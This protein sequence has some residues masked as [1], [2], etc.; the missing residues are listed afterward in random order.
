MENPRKQLIDGPIPGMGMTAELGG[1]PWQKPPQYNTVEEALEFY[2]PR[3]TEPEIIEN[4][5]DVMEL[6]IPLTTIAEGMQ[7]AA[8]ME[9]MHTIDVGI[10]VIPVLVEMMA[11]IGDDAGVEYSTGLEKPINQ[12]NFDDT[13]IALAMKKL[14]E[15]LPQELEE[16][17]AERD[18]IQGE[19]EEPVMEEEEQQPQDMPEQTGLMARRA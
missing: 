5:L 15:R 8:V 14:E 10:L 9:G 19:E 1:R 11:Y 17:K 7:S 18:A 4:L 6:G 16:A 3:F 2:I 12:E 13:K